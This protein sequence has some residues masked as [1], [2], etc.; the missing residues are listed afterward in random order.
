MDPPGWVAGIGGGER[1]ASCKRNEASLRLQELP[2]LYE[3]RWLCNCVAISYKELERTGNQYR[4]KGLCRWCITLRII[5]FM[6][7]IHRPEF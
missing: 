5:G 2:Q 1:F 3:L 4:S 7:C 6:D